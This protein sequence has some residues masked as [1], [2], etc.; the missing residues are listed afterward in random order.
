M[1]TLCPA[2]DPPVAAVNPSHACEPPKAKRRSPTAWEKDCDPADPIVR[3]IVQ[4]RYP[5]ASE[6]VTFVVMTSPAAS[7]GIAEITFPA[8][9]PVCAGPLK[10]NA[11]VER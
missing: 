2:N 8:E 10:R 9:P 4:L 6:Y 5:V 11:P 1:L 3:V 7:A